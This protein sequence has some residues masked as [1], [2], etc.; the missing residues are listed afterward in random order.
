MYEKR[1]VFLYMTHELTAVRGEGWE[2][3]VFSSSLSTHHPLLFLSAA[4]TSNAEFAETQS[5]QRQN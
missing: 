1:S 5:A 3:D 2:Q 4:V